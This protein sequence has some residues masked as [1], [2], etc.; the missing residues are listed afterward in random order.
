MKDR[1]GETHTERDRQKE[2]ETERKAQ[3]RNPTSQQTFMH[4]SGGQ[5]WTLAARP[6]SNDFTIYPAWL[7]VTLPCNICDC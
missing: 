3:K 7:L 6:G 4:G 2:T 5:T 1:G